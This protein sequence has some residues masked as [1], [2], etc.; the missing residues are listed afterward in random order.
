MTQKLSDVMERRW[1]ERN[2]SSVYVF[3]KSDG[4]PLACSAKRDLL[5]TLCERAGVK[6]FGFHAIRHHVASILSDSGKAT[7]SQIQQFLRHRRP[8]TT[9][10]YLHTISRDLEELTKIPDSSDTNPSEK[11]VSVTPI[12]DQ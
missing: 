1:L 6:P 3:Y 4:S 5:R 9:E 10:T 7:L 12:R 8:T 2:K 11:L